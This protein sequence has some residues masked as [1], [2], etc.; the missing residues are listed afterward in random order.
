MFDFV[1]YAWTCPV[2]GSTNKGCQ[3][4]QVVGLDYYGL[5]LTHRQ[6]SECKNLYDFCSNCQREGVTVFM[7]VRIETQEEAATPMI[8]K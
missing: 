5:S 1:D 6:P 8:R 7:E 2:C 3:T 4:K